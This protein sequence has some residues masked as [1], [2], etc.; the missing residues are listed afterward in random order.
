LSQEAAVTD[1]FAQRETV[2]A[3]P[4]LLWSNLLAIE[5][6]PSELLRITLAAQPTAEDGSFAAHPFRVAPSLMRTRPTAFPQR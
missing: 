1:W 3:K 6:L 2:S 4:E 5:E